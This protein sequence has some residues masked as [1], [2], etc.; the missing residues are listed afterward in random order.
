MIC[1]IPKVNLVGDAFLR[2]DDRTSFKYLNYATDT[3]K[4]SLKN[5]YLDEGYL[6]FNY[7]YSNGYQNC[8][9]CYDFFNFELIYDG[10]MDIDHN[11]E[12]SSSKKIEDREGKKKINPKSIL[13]CS[14]NLSPAS[15]MSNQQLKKGLDSLDPLISDE[16]DKDCD[17]CV[18]KTKIK[19]YSKIN[20]IVFPSIYEG[21]LY[22]D[23]N[24]DIVS[25][26]N[27]ITK[28]RSYQ[29]RRDEQELA[30]K[31]KLHIDRFKLNLNLNAYEEIKRN[32][33]YIDEHNQIN[34]CNSPKFYTTILV[35]EQFLKLKRG[36]IRRR[37]MLKNIDLKIE[38]IKSN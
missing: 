18:L 30:I 1:W 35:N 10:N 25:D 29:P 9:Y 36:G 33:E 16:C 15:R 6:C 17:S 34:Y 7:T 22:I 38:K 31:Y 28:Y 19:E 5:K 37:R 24:F 13:Q 32:L 12:K 2:G 11:V 4:Q 21:L 8:L 27:E 23:D 3:D 20:N 26:Y 14:H